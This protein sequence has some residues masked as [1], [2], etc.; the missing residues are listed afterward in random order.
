MERWFFLAEATSLRNISRLTSN[1]VFF[2]SKTASGRTTDSCCSGRVHPT[3]R[4]CLSD[5]KVSVGWT[6]RRYTVMNQARRFGNY[7]QMFGKGG[8]LKCHEARL[9]LEAEKDSAPVGDN[10]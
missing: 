6:P 5:W 1:E 3:E 8:W 10:Q 2:S 4:L 9:K 7:C